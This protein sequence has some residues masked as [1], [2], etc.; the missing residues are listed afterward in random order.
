MNNFEFRDEPRKLRLL[1]TSQWISIEKKPTVHLHYF[2]HRVRQNCQTNHFPFL[3]ECFL[4]SFFNF[5]NL[6]NRCCDDVTWLLSTNFMKDRQRECLGKILRLYRV[7]KVCKQSFWSFLTFLHHGIENVEGH[8]LWKFHKKFKGKVG[9]K[10]Y[11]RPCPCDHLKIAD[12][13][14]QSLQFPDSNVRSAFLK[15]RPPEKCKLRTAEVSP[16]RRFNLRKATTCIK[17]SEKHFIHPPTFPTQA[18]QTSD[19]RVCKLLLAW[20]LPITPPRTRG[21]CRWLMLMARAGA[22]VQLHIEI[23][24]TEPGKWD[25]PRNRTTYSQSLR[26][27]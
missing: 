11:S 6:K 9:Q 4:V 3:D 7:W 24:W 19:I 17:L 5:L 22:C 8:L 1:I 10:R 20:P 14:F 21:S 26:W 13:H 12:T 15:M 27:S 25:N 18:H 23:F 2:I 16:K